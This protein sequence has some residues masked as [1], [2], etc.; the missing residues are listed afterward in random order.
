M[1]MVLLVLDAQHLA[2]QLGMDENM[3]Q[4][5]PLAMSSKGDVTGPK[6][7][8]INRSIYQ[9]CAMSLPKFSMYGLFGFKTR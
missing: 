7:S 8:M 4:T 2:K 6:G 1:S 9:S 3:E 5:S